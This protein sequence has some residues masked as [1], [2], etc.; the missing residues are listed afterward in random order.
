VEHRLGNG[1]L[2]AYEFDHVVTVHL[3]RNIDWNAPEPFVQPGDLSLRPFFGLRSGVPR[4]NPDLGS[5]LVRDSSA[6]SNYTANNFRAEYRLRRLQMSASYSLS[7]NKSDDDNERQLTGI[8]YQNPFN[9]GP[10]YNWSA[11]DA[12]HQVQGYAA[13]QGPLGVELSGLFHFRSGLPIDAT[14]G[15]DTSELLSGEIGNRPLVRPGVPMLRDSFRNRSYR[16]IDLRLAKTVFSREAARLKVYAD[17]FN[18]FNFDNVA[19]IPSTI[20]P[21]NPAFIY[22][23]G[24]LPNGQPAPINS[25]FLQ[26][27]ANGKYDPATTAQQ[28]TPFQVQLGVGFAF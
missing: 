10:E 22:G 4:P 21:N 28:G 15:G 20:Y 3:E 7:F 17:L 9:F 8:T 24:L 27:R 1:L 25:G 23:L 11:I 2:L 18:A 5:V 12:R 26:L 19:F 16:D 13:W 14:T 6:H